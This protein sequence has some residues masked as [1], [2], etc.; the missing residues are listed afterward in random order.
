MC[1]N[2]THFFV[3]YGMRLRRMNFYNLLFDFRDFCKCNR[4]KLLVFCICN[5]LAIVLGVRAAFAVSDA[6]TY[7][8]SHSC[9]VFLF[10][11]G[12]RSIF[13]YFFLELITCW[14]VLVLLV[15]ASVHFLLSYL[16]FAI[17]FFRTYLFAFYLGLYIFFLKVSVLPFVILCAVPCYLLCLCIYMTVAVLSLNRARDA[18]R[19]GA[20]CHNTFPRYM[21]CMLIPCAML[22]I[23]H[24]LC[25]ILSYFLTFGIIL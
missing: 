3:L 14:V 20:G 8:W 13:T 7:L 5:L 2:S 1:H 25:T 19:Y 23:V 15:F 18:W 22:V 4:G 16:C 11:A 24:I 12:K 10:L 21:Q 6:E 9:N 17:L